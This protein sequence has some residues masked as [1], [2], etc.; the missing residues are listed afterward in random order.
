[1]Q[2]RHT[3]Y[4]IRQTKIKNQGSVVIASFGD[5]YKWQPALLQQ[6]DIMSTA[7]DTLKDLITDIGSEFDPFSL[8]QRDNPYPF[9][10][11]ARKEAPVFYSPELKLWVVTKYD[12]ISEILKHPTHFSSLHNFDPVYPLSSEVFDVLNQGYPNI[13]ILINSDLPDHTRLHGLLGTVFNEARMDAMQLRIQEIANTLVDS[14]VHNGQAD[15]VEQYT[16]FL[17][18]TM[19]C[20]LLG[21]P[22][23]DA[24]LLWRWCNSIIKLLWWEISPEENLACAH[25]IVALHHYLA[26]QIEERRALPQHD[27]LT[28]LLN[29]H[30]HAEKPLTTS[31]IVNLATLLLFATTSIS[32][33]FIANALMLLLSHPSQ[34][35]ALRENP[36]LM[37]NFVEESVRMEPSLRAL[38]RT[39]KQDFQIH[40]VEIPAGARLLVILASANHDEAHF[41]DP[42]RFDIYRENLQHGHNHKH[43]GFGHGI[44]Y[45]AGAHLG[46]LLCRI[47]TQVLLQRLPN[48]RLQPDQILEFEPSVV[49][50]GLKRLPVEWDVP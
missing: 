38:I 5:C 31:E 15:L 21:L 37:A 10:S 2:F 20:D 30:L 16:R 32:A 47:V 17:P 48:L 19:I 3:S 11:R 43:L 24:K 39:A 46:R 36:T 12:D 41:P 29:A 25:N 7:S 35:Q 49:Y 44:H 13:L 50:R 26:A 18:I 6:G 4:G 40:G 45:C 33:K 9:Y 14:F 34:L 22:S 23:T 27:M 1:L 8:P 42:D 28:D